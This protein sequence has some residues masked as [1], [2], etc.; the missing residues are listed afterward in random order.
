MKKILVVFGL[1]LFLFSAK[2][3]GNLQFNRVFILESPPT[4]IGSGVTTVRTFNVPA[5]KVWKVE[6]ASFISTSNP[7]E[8][9]SFSLLVDNLVMKTVGINME[10]IINLP[11]WLPEGDHALKAFVNYTVIGTIVSLNVIEYNIIP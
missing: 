10:S 4:T 3:Q 8:S 2:G 11:L 7:A 1:L 9:S 6:A 5:D